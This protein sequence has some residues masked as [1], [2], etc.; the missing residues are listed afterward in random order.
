M[1]TEDQPC[2]VDGCER[3]ATSRGWCHLHYQRDRLHGTT[4]LPSAHRGPDLMIRTEGEE[5]RC[6]ALVAALKQLTQARIASY[7]STILERR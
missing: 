3:A 2:T 1:A 5:D 7:C 6:S 4:D